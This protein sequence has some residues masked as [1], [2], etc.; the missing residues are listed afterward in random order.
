MWREARAAVLVQ[1]GMGIVGQPKAQ[2][3]LAFAFLS[4]AVRLG[5]FTLGS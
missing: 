2:H 5:G 3:G 4:T 1:G